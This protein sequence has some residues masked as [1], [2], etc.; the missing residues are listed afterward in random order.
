MNRQKPK[1]TE[2]GSKMTHEGN[3]RKQDERGE[4]KTRCSDHKT[5]HPDRNQHRSTFNDAQHEGSDVIIILMTHQVS[6]CGDKLVSQC[7]LLRSRCRVK[8]RSH[9]LTPCRA[10][11]CQTICLS[12]NVAPSAADLQSGTW[13][14]ASLGSFEICHVASRWDTRQRDET[15]LK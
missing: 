3:T 15:L 1:N 13:S 14:S 12:G 7:L 5:M 6:S 10:C 4:E 9:V 2:E 8:Q 11:I